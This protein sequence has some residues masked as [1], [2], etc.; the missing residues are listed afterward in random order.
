MKKKLI[1]GAKLKQLR[2]ESGITQIQMAKYLEISRETVI[3]IENNHP[4]SIDNLSFEKVNSW[5]RYCRSK[6][7]RDTYEEW[8]NYLKKLLKLT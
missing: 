8:V 4:G 6:V 5:G 2:K 1:D 3:A 7:S